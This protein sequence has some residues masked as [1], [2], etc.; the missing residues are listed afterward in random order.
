MFKTVLIL[1]IISS[2]LIPT[3]LFAGGI[4]LHSEPG[5]C[6]GDP[7]GGELGPAKTPVKL[8]STVEIIFVFL[9]VIS[10]SGIACNPI[11][12]PVVIEQYENS[13]D[14]ESQTSYPNH[15]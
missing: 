14:A 11:L 7:E 3:M 5:V 9:P 8:I 4:E 6:S 1:L 15:R 12:I 2:M 10:N 13:K